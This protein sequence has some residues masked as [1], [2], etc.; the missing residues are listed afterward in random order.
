MRWSM[1][2]TLNL[3]Q[4]IRS[5][6]LVST[7]TP[8]TSA[9]MAT[10]TF[11]R[12]AIPPIVTQSCLS[13][14]D[15]DSAA[16][17]AVVFE[18]SIPEATYRF[19]CC[20]FI[21][22][23]CACVGPVVCFLIMF[24]VDVLHKVVDVRDR[25]GNSSLPPWVKNSLDVPGGIFVLCPLGIFSIDPIARHITVSTQLY[26]WSSFA[27][28]HSDVFGTQIPGCLCF[29][30]FCHLIQ[31]ASDELV[32]VLWRVLLSSRNHPVFLTCQLSHPT[33]V[34]D[35]ATPTCASISYGFLDR[36]SSFLCVG[37][38]TMSYS[39]NYT[40]SSGRRA[41]H[42]LFHRTST[43]WRATYFPRFVQRGRAV[44]SAPISFWPSYS[45]LSGTRPTSHLL[46]F[47]D[48]IISSLFLFPSFFSNV[49]CVHDSFRFLFHGTSLLLYIMMSFLA[50]CTFIH[51]VNASD[52]APCCTTTTGGAPIRHRQ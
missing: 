46:V 31:D 38:A 41:P 20:G 21:V 26:W 7:R 10:P 12:T 3:L 47:S 37:I 27:R 4:R 22:S 2:C 52:D 44:P 45:F 17:L 5:R 19:P 1:F 23:L 39:S 25:Y 42:S 13:T 40:L 8:R 15:H 6:T 16:A 9:A 14:F 35:C 24:P 34:H 51:S 18:T 48:R 30:F 32:P 49:C 29:L 28:V 36:L 11:R 43:P 50:D 33:H